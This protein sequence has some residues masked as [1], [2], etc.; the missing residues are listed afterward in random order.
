MSV[1]IVTV[2]S[3]PFA[4]NSYV[5]WVEGSNAALVVDPGFEPDVILDVLADRELTLAAILCTHGHV[6]HI[7]GNAALKQRFPSAPLIIGRGDAPMLTDPMLNL[8]G[9]FGFDIV[10]PPA[11]RTVSDGEQ[12]NLAG[13]SWDVREIPGHSPGHVVYILREPKPSLVLGGDVLFRGSIG[14]TDF[15]GGDFATLTAGIRRVLW[16]LPP[17]TVV[18]PGHGPATTI[19]HERRTNPFLQD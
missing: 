7:A 12:L 14:R 4:E 10:S 9:L 18:Y 5:L 19:G 2:E 1:Q 15:P 3:A 16:P 17:D 8:S 6:D 11:D 13:M